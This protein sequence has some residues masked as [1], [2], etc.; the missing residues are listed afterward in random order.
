MKIT[1]EQLLAVKPVIEDFKRCPGCKDPFPLVNLQGKP[2][3]PEPSLWMVDDEHIPSKWLVLHG[4]LCTGVLYGTVV[5][6]GP[7]ASKNEREPQLVTSH[8]HSYIA[9]LDGRSVRDY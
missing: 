6:R 4:W 7:D 9:N 1:K 8:G 3:M 2:E 5:L